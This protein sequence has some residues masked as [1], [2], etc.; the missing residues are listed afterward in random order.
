MATENTTYTGTLTADDFV[1]DGSAITNIDGAHVSIAAANNHIA[2]FDNGTSVLSHE[3]RVLPVQGGTGIDTSASTGFAC[4]TAGTWSVSNSPTIVVSANNTA[5][6][7][8]GYLQTTDATT[9]TIVTL[10]M[11]PTGANTKS[12]I[13][14]KIKATAGRAGDVG[15]INTEN[16]FAQYEV[17]FIAGTPDVVITKV[18]ED[19]SGTLV[20]YTITVV[21]SGVNLN[22]RVTGAVA[23]VVNWGAVVDYTKV[24]FA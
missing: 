6:T 4:V 11:T 5:S 16:W 3:V 21:N 24:S 1:G 2:Y 10:D 14:L 20:A 23:T 12:T 15:S 9:T 18:T 8:Y 7:L 19:K 22:V 13:A 17:T